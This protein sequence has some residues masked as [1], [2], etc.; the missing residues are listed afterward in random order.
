MSRSAHQL[1]LALMELPREVDNYPGPAPAHDR[2][3]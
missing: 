2:E 1:R 3:W